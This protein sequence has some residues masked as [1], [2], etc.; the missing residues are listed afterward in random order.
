MLEYRHAAITLSEGR[1]FVGNQF[2]YG[3]R[4]QIGREALEEPEIE[5]GGDMASSSLQCR[6]LEAA[7]RPY[8]SL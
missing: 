7:H 5:L 2:D 4:E 3:F 6:R 1:N 8:S